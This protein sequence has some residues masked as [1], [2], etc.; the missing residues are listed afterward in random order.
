MLPGTT[1]VHRAVYEVMERVEHHWGSLRMLEK[2]ERVGYA[3]E[4]AIKALRVWRRAMMKPVVVMMR[5]GYEITGQ[6]LPE[7]LREAQDGIRE[8][9]GKYRPGEYGGEVT[10]YR[11][12]RQPRGIYKEREMG[13]GGLVKGG[14]EVYETPG[15]HGAM[16]AEPR[17]KFLAALLTERL[18]RAQAETNEMKPISKRIITALISSEE[19][20]VEPEL[21]CTT[22]VG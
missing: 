6:R 14:V 7:S 2:G 3:K 22:P 16:M 8:A 12:E 10:L 19:S 15:H 1:R 17:V 20:Y 18:S 4:K 21:V 11:A 13:W 9:R 5:R